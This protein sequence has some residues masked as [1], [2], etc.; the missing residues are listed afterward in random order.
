MTLVSIGFD[1]VLKYLQGY[2]PKPVWS[3]PGPVER[4]DT[5]NELNMTLSEFDKEYIFMTPTGCPL[6]QKKEQ[7]F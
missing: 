3:E 4:I 6:S 1:R 2:G 5:L 7:F